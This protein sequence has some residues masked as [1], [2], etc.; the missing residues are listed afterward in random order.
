[1]DTPSKLSKQA[2]NVTKHLNSSFNKIGYRFD[3]KKS[4]HK[5]GG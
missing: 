4:T 5:S 2:H 3:E 1:M